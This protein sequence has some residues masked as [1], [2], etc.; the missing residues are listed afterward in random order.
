LSNALKLAPPFA[1]EAAGVFEAEAAGVFETEAAGVFE[2]EAT[3]DLVGDADAAAG[4]LDA[5]APKDLVFEMLGVL[6]GVAEMLG[7]GGG[8]GGGGAEVE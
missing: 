6:E 3:L 1:G 7:G 8:G 5:D 4:D 2:T